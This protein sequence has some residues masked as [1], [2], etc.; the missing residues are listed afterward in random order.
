MAVRPNFTG[1]ERTGDTLRVSG[2]SGD[3]FN[4]IVDI[5]VVLTQGNRIERKTVQK[6][7]S[8]WDVE[9]PA[10]GFESGDATAFGWETRK[11]NFTT[12]SW[13]ETVPIPAPGEP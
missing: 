9:F 8:V 3:D 6:L 5:Q 2:V 11:D 13:A 7:G 1:V 12:I 10:E 4:E